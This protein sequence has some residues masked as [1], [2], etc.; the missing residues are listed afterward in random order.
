VEEFPGLSEAGGVCQRSCEGTRTRWVPLSTIA[1]WSR[2]ARETVRH[3][4]W[5]DCLRLPDGSS[6][7]VRSVTLACAGDVSSDVTTWGAVT[8]FPF[9]IA[10]TAPR[11][12]CFTQP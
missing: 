12:L 4:G 10:N 1:T 9:N 7:A 6:L 8:Y 5:A 3:K 2:K 11:V